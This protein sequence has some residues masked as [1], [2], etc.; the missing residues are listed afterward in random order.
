[1]TLAG[2]PG[3]VPGVEVAP[4]EPGERARKPQ[5]RPPGA[6]RAFQATEAAE[7]ADQLIRNAMFHAR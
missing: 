6:V 5:A 4:A 7:A 2:P 3:V 1:M